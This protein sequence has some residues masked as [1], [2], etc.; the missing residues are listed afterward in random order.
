[1]RVDM[2]KSGLFALPLIVAV[3]TLL[4]GASAFAQ[5]S[6][7][8]WSSV[9]GTPLPLGIST[10]PTGMSYE[11]SCGLTVDATDVPAYVTTSTPDG[12]TSFTVRFYLLASALSITSGDV[13]LLTAR[14]GSTIEVEILLRTTGSV[15]HLVAVYRDNGSPIEHPNPIPL[16]DVWN[17]VEVTWSAGAG[18]GSFDL[19]LDDMQK[20]TRNDLTNGS[21][22]INEV[23][24]GIVNSAT[25]T[26]ELVLDAF[27]LRRTSA[28][29]LLTVNEMFGISTRADVRTVDE[30]VIGGFIINGDTDKCVVVRGRGP[31]VG[32]PEG[33][34][35]LAD[36]YVALYAGSTEIANNDNWQDLPE[37]Q[38]VIDLGMEP[39]DPLDSSIYICLPAGA[40]TALLSGVGGV[41]GIGIVEVFD[42]DAGTPFLY[43]IS[44]R[45]PVDT[46]N[47]VAIGGFIIDGD[48]SKE[49]VIRGRGPSVGVPEGVTRLSDPLLT[50]YDGGGVVITSNDNWGDAPNAT[51]IT[52]A[53]MEPPDPADSVIMQTL[54][55]GAY[56]AIVSGVGGVTGVGIVEVID[57]TGGSVA[58]Q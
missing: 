47:Q 45:S 23:D 42:A 37:A 5:C 34:T 49:V 2:S 16:Q 24:F 56:T 54:A 17:G 38:T 7:D 58:A 22:V 6:T 20:Y 29:G 35:R 52:A 12:E 32:V 25:A 36:P 3:F 10:S 19:K 46:V 28:V 26:G 39:P 21:A 48:Q 14:N 31:S 13:A 57:L 1:M 43:A 27:D 44:T 4:I 11:Q 18:D 30:I 53:G 50:L 9:T 33:E 15:N 41:Q 55:P 51:E 40:Y 8:A